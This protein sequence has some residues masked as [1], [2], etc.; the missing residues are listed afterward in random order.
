M[1]D[2]KIEISFDDENNDK[3]ESG[4]DRIEI[5]FGEEIRKDEIEEETL[6]Q[7][8]IIRSANINSGFKANQQINNFYLSEI[9][10]PEG[11]E[12]GFRE[13][14]KLELKDSFL[15]S[16][17]ENNNYIISTSVSGS[18]YLVDRFTKKLYKRIS[19]NN[20]PFERTSLVFE[21]AVY[22]NSISALYKLDNTS[23][24]RGALN[25]AVYR[26][27]AGYYIWS[28]LN[29]DGNNI[30]ILEF[31]P[32]AKSAKIVRI[33]TVTGESFKG[34][35][36][37][38]IGSI[39]PL[40]SIIN[41]NAYFIADKCLY[42]LNIMAN[43]YKMLDV[44][45]SVSETGFLFGNGNKLYLTSEDGKIYFLDE[46][47]SS[48]KFTGIIEYHINSVA[49]FDGNIF[50]GTHDGWKHYNS[51]GVLVY[52]HDDVEENRIEAISRNMVVVSK[53]NKIVFHNLN[54]LQEAEGFIIKTEDESITQEIFSAIISYN[55]VFALTKQG[56]LMAY[57]NDKL[58][59]HI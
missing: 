50:I 1:V 28:S 5:D 33:D 14:G 34:E 6:S 43:E 27:E 47:S 22:L 24:E 32:E 16:I 26:C 55:E 17:V 59:I 15:N 10:F 56:V 45:F 25:E 7:D 39:N 30:I 51:N 8:E 19:S 42:I 35:N 13:G 23:I 2:D 37:D 9:K 58:N 49:G 4:V 38:I 36:F 29:R 41:G 40:L 44:G 31:S 46:V 11:I 3:P 21:N 12:K 57:T 54:R 20:E 52:S 18:I 48:L 53:R